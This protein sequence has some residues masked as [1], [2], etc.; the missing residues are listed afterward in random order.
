MEGI[1]SEEIVVISGITEAHERKD[2][3]LEALGISKVSWRAAELHSHVPP[4]ALL[5]LEWSH[6]PWIHPH[7]CLIAKPWSGN[8]S[9]LLLGGV[10]PQEPDYTLAV[11]VCCK[12]E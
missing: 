11:L 10:V 9:V 1:H 3:L 6:W 5:R 8:Q 7:F 4:D 12:E 2:A